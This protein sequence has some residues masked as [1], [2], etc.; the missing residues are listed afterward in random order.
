MSLSFK[1]K[2][3]KL[4]EYIESI[5]GLE[6]QLSQANKNWSELVSGTNTST[7]VKETFKNILREYGSYKEGGKFNAIRKYQMGNPIKNV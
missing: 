4:G 5:K 6:T 1:N 7:G 2:E 3:K